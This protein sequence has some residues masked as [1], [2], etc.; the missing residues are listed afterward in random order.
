[1][2]TAF[3]GSLLMAATLA[4]PAL[5]QDT[6]ATAETRYVQVNG[7]RIAYRRIGTGSPIV[8]ANRMRG[9]LDT[10]DR[11]SWTRSPATIR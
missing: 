9:T 7:D 3:L 6:A 2:K 10:W 8:L 11:C 1:M 4:S 5:A